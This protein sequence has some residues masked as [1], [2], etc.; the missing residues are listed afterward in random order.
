MSPGEHTLRI[1]GVEHRVRFDGHDTP[2]EVCR[3][4]GDLLLQPWSLSEHLAALGQHIVVD[5]DGSLALAPGFAEAVL[6][7]SEIPRSLWA[8]LAPVALWWAAAPSGEDVTGEDWLDLGEIR[9]HLRPWSWAERARALDTA[10]E[11]EQFDSTLYFRDMLKASVVAVDPTGTDLASL[12]AAATQRLL[13]VVVALNSAGDVTSPEWAPQ[14]PQAREITLR[15]CRGLGWTPSKVWAT[16]AIEVDRL[17]AL[18]ELEEGTARVP[19][20]G[21]RIADDPSATVIEIRDDT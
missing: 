18:I 16:P 20:R 5:P 2:L 9:V 17:L 15:I 14:L 1:D 7:A 11:H 12:N 4:D 10:L 21:P 6:K 13:R 8:S 3:P 19:V